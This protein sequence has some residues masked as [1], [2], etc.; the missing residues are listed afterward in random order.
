MSLD[1]DGD[2][3]GGSPAP[4]PSSSSFKEGEHVEVNVADADGG[5]EEEEWLP[6]IVQDALEDGSF[7]VKMLVGY[8]AD[9]ASFD[10]DAEFVRAIP[11][12]EGVVVKASEVKNGLKV[13]VR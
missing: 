2:D 9:S 13:K 3:D 6:A 4:P 7:A 1:L 10:V 5:D 12:R 11:K 8:D